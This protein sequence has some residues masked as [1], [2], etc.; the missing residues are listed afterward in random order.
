MKR[1]S[2]LA[3]AF[4]FVIL[5]SFLLLSATFPAAAH[6]I[7]DD[8][9]GD[10]QLFRQNLT[11][12]EDTPVGI[13]LPV[14]HEPDEDDDDDN[15]D[16]DDDN[17]LIFEVRSGPS[18]GNLTG[19][20]PDL[21][22]TP[23]ENYYGTDT[24]VFRVSEEDDDDD[25]DYSF[26]TVTI[27][28]SPVNDSPVA[29]NDAATT[30]E[31]APL[32][33]ESVLANDTDVDGD[34]LSI[35]GFTQAAGG[36]VESHDDGTFT[37]TPDLN[38]HGIDGF[39]YTVEDGNGGTDQGSVAITVN[40]VNDPP[41][42]NAGTDQTVTQG[43]TVTLDGSESSDVEGDEL[44][45]YWSFFSKPES[46]AAAFYDATAVNPQFVPEKPGT[47]EIQLIVNDATLDSEPDSV[48]II[49][50]PL[51][52]QV[53]PQ[54][55]GSFGEQYEDLVPENA[56]VESY[57]PRR[58][59][60]ITGLVQDL[61]EA[62][63]ADVSITIHSHPEYGTVTTDAAGRFSIPVEGGATTTVMYQKDGLI[64][65]HRKVYVRWNDIAV[66]ETLQM[67]AED[68]AATT[69]T[70]DGNPST[71]VT[72]QSTPVNDGFGNRSASMVFTGDNRAYLVDENG[73]DVQEL[74]TITTRATEFTTEQSMPAKLPPNSAYTYCVE[75]SVDGAQRV[76]FEKP[77]I[78]WVDNFLG[79]DVGMV[80]PAGYY[81]RDRGVWVPADNGV[82]VKL[83][84]TDTDGIVDAL[85]ADGDGLPNDLNSDGSFSDEVTGLDNPARYAP[86][87]SFWRV[88]IIHFTP[89]DIN[90]P[91]G[92]PPDSIP[93]NPNGEVAI[94]EQK[95][96]EDDCQKQISSFVEARSR[97]L[98]EDIPIPGTKLT[99]HYAIN[100][101]PGYFYRITV[102]ASG[103]TVPGSLKRIIARVKV[104]GRVYTQIIGPL[105]NQ[106]AEFGWDGNDHLGRPVIGSTTAHVDVGFVYDIV[107]LEPQDL[108]RAFN[109]PGRD[110]TAVIGRMEITLWKRNDVDITVP[111]ISA[112][113]S[114]VIA[115]G[116]TL[117]AHHQVN[118]MDLSTL[119]KGDGT[120]T[121]NNTAIVDT[122]AGNGTNG[123][124]GDGGSAT[125]AQVTQP[126]SVYLDAEGN[127]YI[128]DFGNHCIRKV[129]TEGIITTIA[130]N[131][132]QGYSGDGGPANEAT[133]YRPSG[134]TEDA[135]GNIYIADSYNHRVRK[136]DKSDII[137]TMAGTGTQGYSGDEGLAT[138]ASLNHPYEVAVDASGN[139]YISDSWNQCIRKVD[140]DGIITTVAGNG[141]YGYSGDGGPA[142]D[143]QFAFPRGIAVDLEGNL[144][145][146]DHNNQRVRKVDNSGIINT[147]AGNGT[148][149]YSG[150]G[151]LATE[152]SI[153]SPRGLAVDSAGNLYIA[154]FRNRVVRKVNTKGIIS[155]M[156]GKTDSEFTY[157]GDGG[158]AT[159]A[160]FNTI[161]DVAVD[162]PNN[163]FIADNNRRIR[164]VAPP[165]AF[166]KITS[167]GDLTFAEESGLGYIVSSA[168]HH[169]KTIDLDT[170][171]TLYDFRYDADGRLASITDRFGDQTLIARDS[172]GWPTSII[173]PDG[174]STSLT[175]DANNQLTGSLTLMTVITLLNMPR[176]VY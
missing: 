71:V 74:T 125:E 157:G 53:E 6:S 93:P 84:D 156:A 126:Y 87:S 107:Y 171:M 133:L 167:E 106:S 75:L 30:N 33:I 79:F 10:I 16:D 47:Y 130:G 58:F 154:D 27:A 55:E 146:A 12:D 46:S 41:V 99:L 57:D 43:D 69:L 141:N 51:P 11:T 14:I 37:Y 82:V 35:T 62:P 24:I 161:M 90:W 2:S 67:I 127:L 173:S 17:L 39:T 149:G 131:G 160:L 5:F 120:Q 142:T 19:T 1:T 54:P 49:A 20:M 81:D 168:G 26:A 94:D 101:V 121:K 52:S 86:D 170:G 100:R 124:S 104:A 68:P 23:D 138:E 83:L 38:F 61:E 105:T 48:E 72:H 134:V 25:D 73:N 77:V 36:W 158:P 31:D 28:I 70:F 78:I 172:S 80:A 97:V 122:M 4:L 112:Q 45:Y 174:I 155:T 115:D 169:K 116:W 3:N 88:A 163:L 153:D 117:S 76:R 108:S 92:P 147:V 139:L 150:D 119:H 110:E 40:Q 145:I 91:Y 135:A 95:N 44:A 7:T 15:D 118:L 113:G 63:I 60:L 66:A 111:S 144:Y 89:W 96:E 159:E 176:V 152:A 22:Y 109:Q 151:G 175:I 136:V 13:L 162:A 123:Y 164:K 128:A 137:T 166:A 42:A 8:D 132:T 165:S 103:V 143:A 85:D 59:S 56:T 21:I 102:P 129:D 65:A 50:E 140:T 18:H 34:P 64:P 32:I 98:H 29:D 9:D 148:Q 114:G